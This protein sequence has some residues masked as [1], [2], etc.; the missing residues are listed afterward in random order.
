M[1]N[2]GR[3]RLRTQ[4]AK[5]ITQ[6]LSEEACGVADM[7]SQADNLVSIVELCVDKY[8]GSKNLFFSGMGKCSFVAG[9]L[10]STFSSLG[11]P[12]FELDCANALHGDV[13]KVRVDD[14]VFIL[15]KS[16]ETDEAIYLAK[17][18]NTNNVSTVAVTCNKE[19]TLYSLCNHKIFIDI[20]SEA[21]HL[22]LAPT[23]S[24][25][26]MLAVGDAIGVATSK[27]L[28]I[29]K[30]DFARSHSRGVLCK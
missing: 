8:K 12:S 16:G 27:L 10:A 7:S 24:S 18:L 20:K 5:S 14:L 4:I 26:C 6:V 2:Q 1:M 19:S 23:T 29:T 28:G 22:G 11:I 15:S 21:C 17:Y 13:G 3:K 30:S 9:K 25:T